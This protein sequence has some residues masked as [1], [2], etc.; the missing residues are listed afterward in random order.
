MRFR[1]GKINKEYI[2]IDQWKDNIIIGLK[3]LNN[4]PNDVL[5]S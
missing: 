5:Q 3:V 2:L 1:A 4:A